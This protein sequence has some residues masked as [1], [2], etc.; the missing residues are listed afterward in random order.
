MDAVVSE[1]KKDAKPGTCVGRK[2][3]NRGRESLTGKGFL[4][5]AKFGLVGS[6]GI[7]VNVGSLWLCTSVFGLFYVL[8]AGIAHI[9]S[10]TNNFTWNQLWTFKDREGGTSPSGIVK[11]WLKYQLTVLVVLA[12]YL[13]VLTLMT[14][15]FGIYYIVSCLCAIAVAFPVNFLISYLWVWRRAPC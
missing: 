14:E 15:V 5:I 11:R 2:W 7:A 6:T 13:S 1:E 4:R 8:S 3:V 10:T 12:V 9:L